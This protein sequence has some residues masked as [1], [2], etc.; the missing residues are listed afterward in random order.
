[1]KTTFKILAEDPEFMRYWGDFLRGCRSFRVN[2][3][4][5]EYVTKEQKVGG[6][7]DEVNKQKLVD[8]WR[9]EGA[10]D[11]WEALTEL[12]VVVEESDDDD[13]E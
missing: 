7:I 3:A 11:L 12:K 9:Q 13:S 4:V 1:M 6:S 2:E 10:L 5:L 8:M